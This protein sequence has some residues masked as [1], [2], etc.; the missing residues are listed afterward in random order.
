[1]AFD[2]CTQCMAFRWTGWRFVR[3]PEP[4]GHIWKERRCA[5]CGH[6]LIRKTPERVE[7]KYR[8]AWFGGAD[9]TKGV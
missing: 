7:E 1:M 8:V 4:D 2:F 5:R 3:R 9:R 6:L